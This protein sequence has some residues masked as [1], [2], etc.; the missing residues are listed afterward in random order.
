MTPA[1]YRFTSAF[2]YLLNRVGVRMGDLFSRRLAEHGLTLPMYRIMAALWELGD[3]SL[4]DLS[5]VTSVELST[6]SRQVGTLTRRRLV[7]R[8]RASR[9]VRIALTPAGRALTEGLIPDAMHFETV[10]LT[11][12]SAEEVAALRHALAHVLDNL[13]ALDTPRTVGPAAPPTR[14]R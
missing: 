5:R 6:L 14:R 9:A 1:D 13:A 2:P 12:L 3:G 11:D 4:G 10:A 7:S 8:A